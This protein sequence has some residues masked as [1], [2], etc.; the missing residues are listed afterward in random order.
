MPNGMWKKGMCYLTLLLVLWIGQ[1]AQ[2]EAFDLNRKGSASIFM[3]DGAGDAVPGGVFTLYHVGDA[4]TQNSN[5]RFELTDAFRGSGVSLNDPNAD[6]LAD[7][8]AQYAKD[9][10]LSGAQK[11]ADAQGH[12][13]FSDLSAGLYLIAQDTP[14]AQYGYSA[15]TAF[16]VSVPM[17][18][19]EGTG[20]VYDVQA[21]PKV[22][23][24][25]VPTPT[26]TPTSPPG[27]G[28]LPQ[29]GALIWP[30][31]TLAGSGLLL[32]AAGWML[33]FMEKKAK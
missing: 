5:L 31:L 24:K 17:T 27:D 16:L 30:A 14:G 33:F 13:K 18:N 32:F 2:A 21:Y 23:K 6:G 8:L 22:E 26:P 3:R 12:V 10:R 28:K 4:V 19:D 9:Q 29:T 11:T 25:P 1:G 15:M 20:W 7:K